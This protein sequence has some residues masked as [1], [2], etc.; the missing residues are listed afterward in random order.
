MTKEKLTL[1]A[2]RQDLKKVTAWSISNKAE[3]RFSYIIPFTLLAILVG[4]FLQNP[5]IGILIF[6]IAAYHIVRYVLEY[7]EYKAKKRAVTEMIERGDISISVEQLSHIAAVTIYE[8]HKG[9]RRGSSAKTVKVF[10]CH[11]SASWRVPPFDR[12]YEWS[13]EYYI[14]TNGLENISIK[15][16]DFYYVSLQKHP[17]IAYIYPCQSFDLDSRLMK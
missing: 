16:N 6:L 13:K 3:W 10:N 15:G 12:H 7:Q 2:I 14:S 9:M 11:S 1:E 17:D 8:P 4:I 5:W